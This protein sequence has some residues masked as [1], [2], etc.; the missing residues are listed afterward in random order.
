MIKENNNGHDPIKI[1]SFLFTLIDNNKPLTLIHLNKLPYIAHGFCL[2]LTNK[3]LSNE[4]PE[5]WPYGP[6]FKSI[7][8]KFKPLG[9]VIKKEIIK[10]EIIENDSELGNYKSFSEVETGIIQQVVINY[11]EK[12][13]WTLSDLTHQKGSPWY[14]VWHKNKQKSGHVISNEVIKKYYKNL[15]SRA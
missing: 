4:E 6:V 10:K 2:A 5:A 1:A 3:P 8:N 12:C 7:F 13:G 11:K 15:L 14:Q 9:N